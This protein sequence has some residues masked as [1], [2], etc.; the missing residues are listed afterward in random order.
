MKTEQD[1]P[2]TRRAIE[3]VATKPFI[4][5]LLVM[6]VLSGVLFAAGIFLLD[7][8][9]EQSAAEFPDWLVLVF[10]GGV[11]FSLCFPWFMI[12]YFVRHLLLSIKALEKANRELSSEVD[13]LSNKVG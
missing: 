11:G 7:R 6:G 1:I 10:V 9:P 5:F 8:V 13:R 4:Y 12:L 2:G 3:Y